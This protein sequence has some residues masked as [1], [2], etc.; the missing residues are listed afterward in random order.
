MQRTAGSCLLANE[1]S[2]KS[3]PGR[4][5][6]EPEERVRMRRRRRESCRQEEGTPCEM[7]LECV[8]DGKGGYGR[9]AVVEVEM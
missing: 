7:E 4:P 2:F 9:M 3:C 1:G 6:A 5:T 8:R